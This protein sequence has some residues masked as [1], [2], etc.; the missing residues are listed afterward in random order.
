MSFDTFEEALQKISALQHEPGQSLNWKSVANHTAWFDRP[1]AL[2]HVA[3]KEKSGEV[4]YED[5]RALEKWVSDGYIVIEGAVPDVDVDEVNSF[6]DNLLITDVA[7]EN[8]TLL[9][10]TLDKEKGGAAVPHRD[11][12]ALSPEQRQ[13]NARLSPWRIHELWTQCDAASRIYKNERLNNMASLIFDRASYPRSTINFYLGSQQ[14]LHQDMAVFHVYPGNYLIGAWV[15]LEDISAE[16]GPL[17]FAPG[18]HTSVQYPGFENHP[19]ANL[20]TCNL[21]EYSGYYKFTN[22]E[23][24][25]AGVKQFIAK[26]GDV[27][28]WHGM[29]VH[30][31]SPVINPELTR[32]SM[33]IHY[34]VDGVDQ[35]DKIAGPFNWG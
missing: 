34:L 5:A 33:V 22:D 25:K 9:G 18:T 16:S 29:L 12:V 28:L 24:G 20:R 8:I 31:G 10:Y 13:E 35:T 32:K 3:D 6:I 14:E 1:D 7:N 21:D 23:A 4:S 15:A 11:L 2:Q 17:R 26:K 19:Q 30:G 27:L